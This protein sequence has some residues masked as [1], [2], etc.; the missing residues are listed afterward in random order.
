VSPLT[1]ALVANVKVPKIYPKIIGRNVG[2]LIRVDRDRMDVVCV[3]V[4]VN[5]AG[6]GGDDVV[7]LHHLWQP[8][9]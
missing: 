8:E 6:N 2:F 5:L 3:S 1:K 9:M 4:G 7:L